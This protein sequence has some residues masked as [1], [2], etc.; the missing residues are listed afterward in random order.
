MRWSRVPQLFVLSLTV[1]PTVEA[2]LEAPLPVGE[3]RPKG[4]L[5]DTWTLKSAH[6]RASRVR[7]NG[8]G[9]RTHAN[10]VFFQ[11]PFDTTQRQRV[12]SV[13]FRPSSRSPTAVGAIRL[14]S[15]CI[16]VPPNGG[17]EDWT[18]YTAGGI[19]LTARFS[20]HP[21]P[22][23]SDPT[24]LGI[25]IP[26]RVA[27]YAACGWDEGHLREPEDWTLDVTWEER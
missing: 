7:L 9:A 16:T 23:T 19:G 21:A 2:P 26:T 3:S 8:L 20:W 18:S 5:A 10:W 24:V 4:P 25:N 11:L 15:V 13:R 27:N 17:V 22:P 6:L 12:R 1:P 14:G